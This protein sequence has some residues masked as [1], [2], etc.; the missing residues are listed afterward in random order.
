M[1]IDF[2]ER[3]L[4]PEIGHDSIL[5]LD[6]ELA[7]PGRFLSQGGVD[8]HGGALVGAEPGVE[9]LVNRSFGG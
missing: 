3:I 1:R 2:L 9:W 7:H 6:H 8:F 4:D 5:E